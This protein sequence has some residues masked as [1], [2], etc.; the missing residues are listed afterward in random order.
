M[1]KD[2]TLVPLAP[3][4]LA[5][6]GAFQAAAILAC[7][8][9]RYAAVPLAL[10]LILSLAAPFFPG[11]GY[12]LPIVSR[13]SRNR[14][15]VALT[16]DDGPDPSTTRRLLEL[17]ERHGVAATFFV[18]GRRAAA[19]RGLVREILSRGHGLGNHSYSHSPLLMLTGTERLRT[20]ITA[21]RSL[22][23]EFGVRTFAFRPPVGI[24]NPR[25]W[26]VLLEEGMYCV[27][28]SRRAGDAGNR[29]IG[30][31]SRRILKRAKPGDIILLHDVSPAKSFDTDRWLA[32]VESII[33]GLRRMNLAILP[34]E[35]LIGRAVMTRSTVNCCR[36]GPVAAF[37]DSIAPSYDDERGSPRQSPVSAREFRLFE[38]R[39]LPRLSP[40][41]RILEIGAGTGIYTI[42]LARK[43]RAVTA[44]EISENMI[45]RLKEKAAREGLQNI[46]FINTDVTDLKPGETY[47]SVCAFSSFEDMADLSR[48]IH[49]VSR[50]LKP[51]G[52]IYFTTAH[53]SL[54]RFFIQI[55]N[56]LRQGLWLHGRSVG[57][58]RKILSSAGFERIEV[59]SHVMKWPLMGGLLI[60]A[61]AVKPG[62]RR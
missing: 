26:R 57:E 60:E 37:Y 44:V 49:L 34:L 24:T 46:N 12:Y 48:I 29:R 40:E 19:H 47:D 35:D 52:I 8:D 31:L 38:K 13:G 62:G 18:T 45:A 42:P 16:F 56:A 15:A 41:H 6:L 54:F 3:A 5:G 11:F 50:H 23:A 32:E 55:G 33:T 10:F 36:P 14:R 7:I 9:I 43:S 28:F 25:L 22:L 51:G 21:A 27:N 59:S 39:Y 53:R 2:P 20:E 1:R 61:T 30:G 4:H 17:L 58:V